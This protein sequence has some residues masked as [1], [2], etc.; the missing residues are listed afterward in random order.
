MLLLNPQQKTGD[1]SLPAF[2]LTDRIPLPAHFPFDSL[3]PTP[4]RAAL[5]GLRL[6]HAL[7]SQGRVEGFWGMLKVQ[8]VRAWVVAE[9]VDIK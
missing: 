4:V 3:A 2:H 6:G 9:V 7:Y 8:S 5:P 1:A